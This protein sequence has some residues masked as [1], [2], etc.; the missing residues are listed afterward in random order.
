[1]IFRDKDSINQRYSQDKIKIF[2]LVI[3]L[4]LDEM[5]F[6]NLVILIL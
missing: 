5:L 4:H 6:H 2:P 3:S 1:M